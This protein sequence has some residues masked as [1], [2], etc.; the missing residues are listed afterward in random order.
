MKKILSIVSLVAVFALIL[1]A[2]ATSSIKK[3]DFDTAV[4]TPA[5]TLG[6][7]ETA[8]RHYV[9]YTDLMC[10]YCNYYAKAIMDGGEEF[11]QFLAEHKILYEVRLTDMLYENGV[12]YSRPAAEAGYCAANTNQ[13]WDFYHE[14]I[15]RIFTDYY[16][17]GIGN[18]KTATPIK[19]LSLDYWVKIASDAGVDS[20]FEDCLKIGEMEK[21]WE[22]SKKGEIRTKAEI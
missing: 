11:E 5:M 7:P 19:D 1:I 8:V 9:V 15:Y 13:F 10:P 12:E 2:I 14:A 16:S 22:V 21:D 18:S 3:P 17:K 4:W 6:N 20:G